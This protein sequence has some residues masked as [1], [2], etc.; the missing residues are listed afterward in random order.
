METKSFLFQNK[1]IQYRVYGEGKPVI[2][3]HGF[4]EDSTVWQPQIN[5]LKKDF[6]LIVPDI[7]GSGE[8]ELITNANIDTYAE[9]IKEICDREFQF[10][11][12]GAEGVI[13]G[14]SMGGYIT[15]ALAEKY[16]QYLKAFGLFHSS[17]FADNEE[18]IEARKKAI[19]FIKDKGAYTFLKTSTPNLFTQEYKDEHAD[20][21]E[22]LIEDGKK[23]TDG[24]LIQY[25]EAM[26]ARPDRTLVL[27][28]FPK[29]ILFIIGQQDQAI[30]F[31]SSMKQCHL[32]SLSH[33]H[34]LR[35]SAHMGM[36]EE[37]AKANDILLSFLTEI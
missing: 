19:D 1:K 32:P 21:V 31:E 28:S 12:Q 13:I 3:L 7:P 25:Y 24:A 9:I 16:P 33:V 22:T 15:L 5:F 23:F 34:I 30:P 4:G 26:I 27:K 35:Q 6:L 29:P 36:W 18:K 10:P 37:E 11:L 17:A 20:N 14:H 2:L 8:S